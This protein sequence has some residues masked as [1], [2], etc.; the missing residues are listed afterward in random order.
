VNCHDA[1]CKHQAEVQVFSDE[2]HHATIPVF[3]SNNAGS[4][5]DPVH[6]TQNEQIP[7]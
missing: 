4:C 5:F 6:E 7:L 1:R 3:P 2:E